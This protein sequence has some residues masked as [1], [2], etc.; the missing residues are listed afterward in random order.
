MPSQRR[1]RL[2]AVDLDGTL[3]DAVGIPHPEDV[4][5]IHRLKER[6]VFVSIL[7]GRL[8]SGSRKSAEALG[9]RGPIGCAD[10][11]HLV[12][13]SDGETLHHR[14]IQGDDASFLRELVANHNGAAFV[15]AKDVILHDDHGAP[16]LPYIATWSTDLRR[17]VP[18]ASHEAWASESGITSMI[19]IGAD[20]AMASAAETVR[21]YLGER[22]QTVVFPVARAPGQTAMMVRAAGESKGT[23]LA[24]LAE[25]H[26][27]SLEETV[28]VGDWLNDIPMMKAAGMSFAMGQAPD[29]VKASATYVLRAT[30]AQGGGIAAAIAHAFGPTN[31]G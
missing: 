2:L 7:T 14:G 1:P 16:Y 30:S 13:A 3:L 25:H 24:W 23:A 18:L 9:I 6:G 11:S 4:D 15:L 28:C 27:I 5:A 10:G 17:A 22:A 26:G 20:R 12:R 21:A 19:A 29:A 31:G 8:Y